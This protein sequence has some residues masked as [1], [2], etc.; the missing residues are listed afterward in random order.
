LH[1]IQHKNI[2]NHKITKIQIYNQ[3][4]YTFRN[5]CRKFVLIE[6]LKPASE[7]KSVSRG[8]T[9]QMRSTLYAKELKRVDEWHVAKQFIVTPSD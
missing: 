9:F 6:L 7:L 1:N 4:K 2:I 5:F 3:L 8:K